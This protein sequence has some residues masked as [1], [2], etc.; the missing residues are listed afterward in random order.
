[1]EFSFPIIVQYNAQTMKFIWVDKILYIS[2][3]RSTQGPVSACVG[4]ESSVLNSPLRLNPGECV[5]LRT[6]ARVSKTVCAGL[7]AL[8]TY[9]FSNLLRSLF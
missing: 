1:M 2:Q 3:H 7:R 9:N 8:S 4:T 5:E 6:W